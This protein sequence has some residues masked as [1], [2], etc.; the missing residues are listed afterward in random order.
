MSLQE[1]FR[2]AEQLAQFEQA[3]RAQGFHKFNKRGGFYCHSELNTYAA[4][5]LAGLKSKRDEVV[6]ELASA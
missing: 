5:Y 4:G 3:A 1:L 2:S 6:R